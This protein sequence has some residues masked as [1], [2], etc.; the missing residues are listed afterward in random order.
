MEKLTK[1]QIEKIFSDGFGKIKI[2]KVVKYGMTTEY[3]KNPKM[4]VSQL[5]KAPTFTIQATELMR[6]KSAENKKKYEANEPKEITILE[7]AK[8]VTKAN[9]GKITYK[10][11]SGSVYLLIGR[12]TVR[13]SD[14][15][16]LER[17]AMNPK[18]RFNYEIVQKSFSENDSTKIYY[19]K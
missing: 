11:K 4:S 5:K 9:K 8:K 7:Y 3:I 1:A 18:E 6:K 10:S 13:I 19:E 12:E 17:D 14:H 16:I 15:Y 2:F